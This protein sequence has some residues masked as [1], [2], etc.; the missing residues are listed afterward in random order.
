M[1][2]FEITPDDF[3]MMRAG[4][5]SLLA[6]AFKML[7][8]SLFSDVISFVFAIAFIMAET[9]KITEVMDSRL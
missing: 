1:E 6:Q 9:R 5:L 3:E 4:L 7:W 2:R 8:A